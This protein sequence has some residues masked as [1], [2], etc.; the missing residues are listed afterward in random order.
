MAT[1]VDSDAPLAERAR[2]GDEGAFRELV[3][4]YKKPLVNFAHR[5]L[6]DP[7]EAEDVA[8]DAFVKAYRALPG[9]RLDKGAR[10]STWLFQIARN[11]AIDRIRRSRRI[12]FEPLSPGAGDPPSPLRGPDADAAGRETAEAVASAI[13]ALPEDQRTAVV[14]S[15][16]HGMTYAEIAAVMRVSIKSVESRLYRARQELRARLAHWMEP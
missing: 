3:E 15:E 11:L 13:Q 12:H 8:Q 5:L 9:L 7:I 16:Y 10:F 2:Q 1:D 6:G 14:L 4:R